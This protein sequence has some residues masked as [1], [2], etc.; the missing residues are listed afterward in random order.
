MFMFFRL[1]ANFPKLTNKYSRSKVKYLNNK[2]KK[3]RSVRRSYNNWMFFFYP[4]GS[5]SF[6]RINAP[7]TGEIRCTVGASFRIITN[8]AHLFFFA[9]EFFGFFI[10]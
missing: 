2:K 7:Q 6:I 8:R 9:G 3:L 1:T 10:K 4:T 5:S